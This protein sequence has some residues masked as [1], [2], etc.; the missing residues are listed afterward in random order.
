MF[1]RP[2][3]M[4]LSNDGDSCFNDRS[5]YVPAVTSLT[6]HRSP[7]LSSNER[8]AYVPAVRSVCISMIAVSR[9]DDYS[10]YVPR[11]H[12][13]RR[14]RS[15]FHLSHNTIA[16]MT[17]AH[18]KEPNTSPYTIPRP[19]PSISFGFQSSC[20]TITKRPPAFPFPIGYAG[21]RMGM[22]TSKRFC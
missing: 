4:A 21:G 15:S 8:G 13:A 12:A 3:A 14:K 7:R 10:A 22:R 2:R 20:W 17:A 1:L 5:A 16:P 19:T 9:S 6:F 11:D 18:N